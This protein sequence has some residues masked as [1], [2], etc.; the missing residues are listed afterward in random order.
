M[1]PCGGAGSHIVALALPVL[2]FGCRARFLQIESISEQ[3]VVNTSAAR[4][5]F[6]T[7]F[8]DIFSAHLI[9]IRRQL[10]VA[11]ALL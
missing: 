8:L 1:H 5:N 10:Y 7:P 2:E 9:L 3:A 6:A 4:R 11:S